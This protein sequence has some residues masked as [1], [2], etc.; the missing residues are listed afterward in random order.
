MSQ[1]NVL[2]HAGVE[3]DKPMGHQGLLPI[4]M[5]KRKETREL[6]IRAK[7]RAD[8][9]VRSTCVLALCFGVDSSL[10]PN[11]VPG[12]SLLRRP[13]QM[14][15]GT[16][17]SYSLRIESCDIGKITLVGASALISRW[18]ERTSWQARCARKQMRNGVKS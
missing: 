2:L 3:F 13:S 15:R 12:N 5:T 1:V 4:Q 14:T 8:P 16:R 9:N 10:K 17:K 6:L 7:E 11:S 18:Y